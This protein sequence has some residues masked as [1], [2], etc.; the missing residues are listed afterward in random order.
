MR[1]DCKC[2]DHYNKKYFRTNQQTSYQARKGSPTHDVFADLLG[3]GFSGDQGQVTPVNNVY[4]CSDDHVVYWEPG[5]LDAVI[6]PHHIITCSSD[7][8]CFRLAVY[9]WIEG[10]EGKREIASSLLYQTILPRDSCN[11]NVNKVLTMVCMAPSE[12]LTSKHT[13]ITLDQ[14]LFSSLFCSKPGVNCP[15][16]LVGLQSGLVGYIYVGVLGCNPQNTKLETLYH[17]EQTVISILP[18]CLKSSSTKNLSASATP[19]CNALCILGALGKLVLITHEDTTAIRE[20]H[21]PGPIV[22]A[23]ISNN[24]GTLFYSTV[25]EVYTVPLQIENNE[26]SS[27]SFPLT[28]SPKTLHIPKVLALTIDE[29]NFLNCLATDGRLLL[30]AQLSE[31]IIPACSQGGDEIKKHLEKIHEKASKVKNLREEIRQLDEVIKTLNTVTQ[32]LCEILRNR[33]SQNEA[34]ES[35]IFFKVG[36]EYEA[37]GASLNPR[38]IL[39]CEL[40]N[41][42][43]FPF[44]PSWSLVI[45]V[46]TSEPWFNEECSVQSTVNHS[47]SLSHA[48]SHHISIYLAETFSYLTPV[49]VSCYL[50]FGLNELLPIFLKDTDPALSEGGLSVFVSRTELNILNFLRKQDTCSTVS[51][52]RSYQARLLQ[53]TLRSM[54]TVGQHDL[55][56]VDSDEFSSFS[57]QLSGEA[58]DFI[59]AHVQELGSR[60][61]TKFTSK[62]VVSNPGSKQDRSSQEACVLYYILHGS[63]KHVYCDDLKYQ[64]NYITVR[65]PNEEVVKLQVVSQTGTTQDIKGLEVRIHTSSQELGC[66]LHSSLLE[67]FK[68][69]L[70]IFFRRFQCAYW[71]YRQHIIV[72]KK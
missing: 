59:Q 47:V 53:N 63:S 50:A 27:Y 25:K 32:V 72:A 13:S 1:C 23:A 35:G 44:S 48:S 41:S 54:N 3:E 22:S 43:N 34:R 69:G 8:S 39:R 30:V 29:E 52:G 31:D 7:H 38:V 2:F 6:G 17:L 46:N 20:Y 21:V 68:V 62:P 49:Q 45:Q 37:Q 57:I 11:I 9:P 5:L 10:K 14:Q 71:L 33:D 12:Q 19:T 66:S 55:E 36:V 56:P 61:D 40:V 26:D 18:V 51:Q 58:V 4:K 28:V 15:I 60:N 42:T 65:T 16:V 70:S 64:G 67:V 24:L